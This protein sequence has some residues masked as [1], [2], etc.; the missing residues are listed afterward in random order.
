MLLEDVIKN[1]P[2]NHPDKDNLEEALRQIE[3]VAW[4]INDQLKEHENALK[5]LDIQRSLQGCFPKIVVPGRRLVKQGNLMKVP[6]AG[7]SGN[8][9]Y[10][11]LFSDILMYCKIKIAGT[12][13]RKSG[14]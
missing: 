2:E 13:I 6:R 5:M 8:P 11:V 9:R 12:I 7:G 10:F 4:H 1:T 3:S 14:A